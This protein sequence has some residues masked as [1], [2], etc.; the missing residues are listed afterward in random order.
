MGRYDVVMKPIAPAKR[1]GSGVVSIAI[2][3]ALIILA[4]TAFLTL[5]ISSADGGW[6]NPYDALFTS[7]SA[8]CTTGLVVFDTQEHWSF[9][10]ELVILI[11]FQV[12]GLGYMV[13]TAVVLW[14]LGRRLGVRDHEMLRL[15]YGAPD[16]SETFNF[17]KTIGLYALAM[18]AVG[19]VVLFLA[20]GFSG[21]SWPESVWFGIFHSVS[22][23]N[24]AGFNVTG[25]DMRPFADDPQV[26]LPLAVLAIAGSIGGVP[27]VVLASR[28]SFRN[29]PLDSKLI[30]G[31]TAILLVSATLLLLTWEWDNAGT[32]GEAPAARKPLLAFFQASMWTTGFSAVDIGSLGEESKLFLW[33]MMFV[34]GAPGSAA[35]GI[36]VGAFA[37]LFF[38][39]VATLR[40]RADVEAL[41]R[42]VP[43]MVVRQALTVTLLFVAIV[44]ALG[45]TLVALS[46]GFD[47]LDTVFELVSA[48]ATVGWSAGLTSELDSG[49][50]AILIVAMLLGRFAPLLLVLE[51]TRPRRRRNVRLP[52]DSIRL[53]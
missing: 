23:F 18:E 24:L 7:V 26:L 3:F 6:T 27:V 13:G 21:V 15:Y 52:E 39:L 25:V 51:M 10:G 8:I 14:G 43:I 49:G 20:F 41:G 2:A 35:G 22:A 30:L 46:P 37:L 48:L 12:G 33:G 19:A 1:I 40:G 11:L 28:R 47:A 4:G 45:T 53:G 16:T 17:A 50:R 38:A 36:K 29:L 42:H 9:F 31:T 34:G 32:F 44:F 5:P